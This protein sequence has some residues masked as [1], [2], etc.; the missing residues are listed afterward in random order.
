MF[1]SEED[2]IAFLIKL[3]QAD[4]IL[5]VKDG[6]DK[7]IDS[8]ASTYNALKIEVLNF[9]GRLAPI[10]I[11]AEKKIDIG[12]IEDHSRLKLKIEGVLQTFQ[13]EKKAIFGLSIQNHFLKQPDHTGD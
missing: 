2:E 3:S 6:L 10:T 8:L 13:A 12:L 1:R 9:L 5:K 7:K 11:S 4:P